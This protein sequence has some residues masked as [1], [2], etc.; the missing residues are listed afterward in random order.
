MWIWHVAGSDCLPLGLGEAI[1]AAS[2]D[3]RDSATGCWLERALGRFPLGEA[4]LSREVTLLDG[5]LASA[6]GLRTRSA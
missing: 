4:V 5:R 3:H 1:D 2:V 6:P